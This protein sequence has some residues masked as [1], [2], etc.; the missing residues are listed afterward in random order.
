MSLYE[1]EDENKERCLK[2]LLS[3]KSKLKLLPS[4]DTYALFRSISLMEL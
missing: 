2:G 1:K 3:R 4:I